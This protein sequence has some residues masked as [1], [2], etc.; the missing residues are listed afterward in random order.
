[1][2]VMAEIVDVAEAGVDVVEAGMG[3]EKEEEEC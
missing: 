2:A 3:G 1:L